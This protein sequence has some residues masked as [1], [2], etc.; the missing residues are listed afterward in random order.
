MS[1]CPYCKNDIHIED[2]FDNVITKT[3]KKGRIRIK[4]ADFRGEKI[5]F[6]STMKM[7]ACPSCD[8]ILGFSEW[9]AAT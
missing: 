1:K 6:I 4:N 3:T 8:T 9:K 2:F 7:W 5:Y